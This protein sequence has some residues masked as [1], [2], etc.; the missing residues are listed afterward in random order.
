MVIAH[1]A[2]TAEVMAGEAAPGP[3]AVHA[4]LR[5]A[6]LLAQVER[7]VDQ[8]DVTVGLRK[9]AQHAASQWIEL[10]GEQTDIIAAREQ[11]VEQPPSFRIAALQNIVVD[12]PKAARQKGS[13]TCRQAIS[14]FGFVAEDEFAIDQQ[15]ILD[16]PKR[17]PNPRIGWGKKADERQQQ[18]TR[19]EP[20]GAVG[21]YETAKAAVETALT[22][23]GM[24]FVGDLAPPLP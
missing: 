18:Q 1:S 23:F 5:R 14:I 2:T 20:L 22:H 11:T 7:A 17:S 4:L 24:D 16:R 13:L 8:T 3:L 9:I 15:S 6:R 10:F 12:E 21:L 19:V